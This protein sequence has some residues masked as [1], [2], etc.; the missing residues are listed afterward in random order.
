MSETTDLTEAGTAPWAFVHSAAASAQ[1]LPGMREIF[2]YRDLGVAAATNG[3]YVVHVI[4]ANGRTAEDD[5]Q[6]W[7][8]HCCDFQLVYVLSGW[9][10]FEYEGA[11][12]HTIK[13]GDCVLQPPGLVHREIECSTDFSV[14]EVVAP[15]VFKTETVPAPAA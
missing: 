10:T 12:Q 2:D 11:G 9:A 6:Q 4:R 15:A 13:A 8:R 1:W 3:D 14:L 5:V 7:H